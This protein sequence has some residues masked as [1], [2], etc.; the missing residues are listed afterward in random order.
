MHTQHSK[1]RRCESADYRSDP[2]GAAPAWAPARAACTSGSS[3]GRA[4]VAGSP[5][6]GSSQLGPSPRPAPSSV[7]NRGLR[8]GESD[9]ELCTILECAQTS[10]PK[11]RVRQPSPEE[12]RAQ[13]EVRVALHEKESSAHYVV[14]EYVW[15]PPVSHRTGNTKGGHDASCDPLPVCTATASIRTSGSMV[16]VSSHGN[17]VFSSKTFAT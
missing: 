8:L 7:A 17:A 2:Q 5:A 12:L 4:R 6:A 16:A 1:R 11:F 9:K 13:A 3:F 15:Q 10:A 14:V